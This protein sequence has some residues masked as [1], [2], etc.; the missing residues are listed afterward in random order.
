MESL[1]NVVNKLNNK[2]NALILGDFLD[3]IR[4][5]HN[6]NQLNKKYFDKRPIFP[7]IDKKHISYFVSV[8]HSLCN[9]FN[10]KVPEWIYDKKYI[11][12][13]P[14]FAANAKGNL[15][16]ILIAESPSEFRCRNIFVSN[17]A[18]RRV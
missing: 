8:L 9:E 3:D 5:C 16:I 13:D 4:H 1:Q 2:N 15:R 10:M 12:K 14:Y 7:N 17:N 6:L 11:L 18:T